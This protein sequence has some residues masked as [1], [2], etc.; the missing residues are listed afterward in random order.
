MS[1]QQKQKHHFTLGHTIADIDKIQR[2]IDTIAVSWKIDE[3]PLF[4]LN[5]I[6]EELISNTM[7]Y[8]YIDKPEGKIDVELSFDGAYIAVMMED[9]AEEFDPTQMLAKQLEFVQRVCE[10]IQYT[11]QNQKNELRFRMKVK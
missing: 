7:V 10:D 8:G 1:N 9:D 4:Q 3:K 6:L 11:Y 2:A 5:L